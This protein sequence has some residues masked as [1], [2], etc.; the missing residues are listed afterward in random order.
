MQTELAIIGAGPAGLAAAEIVVAYG[1]Q[2]C[3]IDEQAQAGG[4]IYR[5]PPK[6][7]KVERWLSSSV[8]KKV[9][10]LVAKVSSVEGIQWL[11][12]TTVL[13]ISGPEI[14]PSSDGY[15]LIL[16]NQRGSFTLRA[17]Y[18]LIASGCYDMPVSF[19]GW[20]LPGVM[21]TGGIQA[22]VKSQQLIPGERFLFVGTHP[23]QLVVADQITQAGGKV[24][25]VVFAQPLG[26]ILRLLKSPS[27]FWRHGRKLLYMFA[28]ILRLRLKGVPIH[29]SQTLVGAT[30]DGHLEI[31]TVAPIN[32]NGKVVQDDARNIPCDRLG[33]C[34]SFLASSELARQAGADICWSSSGGG[35]V[36]Q[37]DEWMSSSVPGI[38]VAGEITKVAGADVAQYEG[39]L[40]GLGIARAIGRLEHKQASH[41]AQPI[42]R[43]LDSLNQFAD[44]LKNLSYPGKRLLTQLMTD[45]ATLCKCEEVSV[46]AFK[47]CLKQNPHIANANSAKLLSRA[48]MGL[49][50]GRYCHFQVSQLLATELGIDE[51]DGGAFTARFPAKPVRIGALLANSEQDI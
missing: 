33:I 2:V 21:A 8:Y 24:V 31:T 26:S 32:S 30:G 25:G 49:C 17:K 48:G 40:A 19:P 38:F 11:R 22:F 28:T 4:Q 44:A 12:Q 3:I 51:Q 29:F 13:G 16:N 36:V 14:T 42:R 50:Q 27:L 47:D 39:R 7:F 43:Q 23:L 10:R 5:Q 34:F 20:N 6:E 15:E 9:R 46:G 35:W 37:H 41:L 45:S 18:V 1:I